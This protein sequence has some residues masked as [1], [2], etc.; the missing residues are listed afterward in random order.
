LSIAIIILISLITLYSITVILIAFGYS[1]Q[2]KSSKHLRKVSASNKISIVIAARNEETNIAKCLNSILKQQFN[3]N[4]FEIIV[5]NDHST[6]NTLSIVQEFQ[7]NYENIHCFSLNETS[8]KKEAIKLGVSKCLFQIVAVTDA[9]CEVPENWLNLISSQF[10][11]NTSLLIGSVK[12]SSKGGL[13]GA[14]QQ[15]DM[16]ALQGFTFGSLNFNKPIL[17]N[18]ANMVFNKSDY[19]NFYPQETEKIPSGDDMFLLEQF[20][21]HKKNIKGLLHSDFIVNTKSENTLRDFFNQRIRWASKNKHYK[22]KWIQYFGVLIFLTNMSL[23]FIYM[24]LI[25]VE[26]NR[27]VYIILM[28]T[29]WLIDF[30]LL[31]LVSSFFKNRKVLT[32]FLPSQLVYPVYIFAVGVL[33]TFLKI[34]WKGRIYN[35]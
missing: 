10:N 23:I 31:F 13:F 18:A 15:L 28:L 19:L 22:D 14:F 29:K 1:Q 25:F 35:G 8:S 34:S 27:D 9:D 26:K 20:K 17:I 11:N 30:I 5:I 32:Y 21:R 24:Q 6:D 33:S 12:L 4:D 3:H 2:F 7:K 16:F